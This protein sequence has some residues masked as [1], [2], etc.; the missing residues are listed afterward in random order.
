MTPD[1]TD[2]SDTADDVSVDGER[3]SDVVDKAATRATDGRDTFRPL[4]VDD[5]FRRT[6]RDDHATNAALHSAIEAAAEDDDRI[7]S[8]NLMGSH[9][10]GE[11]DHAPTY[12][13]SVTFANG[14]MGDASTGPTFV[15]R[16]LE[17]GKVRCLKA[18]G[19]ATYADVDVEAGLSAEAASRGT[20]AQATDELTVH[21]RPVE[22]RVE[23]IEVPVGDVPDDF[24][25][26]SKVEQDAANALR[27]AVNKFGVDDPKTQAAE[28]ALGLALSPTDPERQDKPHGSVDD[29]RERILRAADIDPKTRRGTDDLGSPDRPP[30]GPIEE[31]VEDNQHAF[32]ADKGEA[33]EVAEEIADT[34]AERNDVPVRSKCVTFE[35]TNDTATVRR[36]QF[37]GGFTLDLPFCADCIDHFEDSVEGA[38]ADDAAT[39]QSLEADAA[40][41]LSKA[42]ADPSVPDSAI[43]PVARALATIVY[44]SDTEGY[45]GDPS[46]AHDSLWERAD[47]DR[48]D[49]SPDYHVTDVGG[50][51][52]A[53]DAIEDETHAMHVAEAIAVEHGPGEF[54]IVFDGPTDDRVDDAADALAL[55]TADFEPATTEAIQFWRGEYDP[56]FDPLIDDLGVADV[57]HGDF[58]S[59]S[60]RQA[61]KCD[62]HVAVQDKDSGELVAQ[63]DGKATEW[64]EVDTGRGLWNVRVDVGASKAAA[65][66]VTAY[67]CHSCERKALPEDFVTHGNVDGPAC[68]RCGTAVDWDESPGAGE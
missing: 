25:R 11:K 63:L 68:P 59:Y 18:F 9:A 23:P 28:Y 29:T 24:V 61:G 35:C 62:V 36:H 37:P 45:D 1:P 4:S 5:R 38:S 3:I 15:G 19:G 12:Y 66:P 41:V 54:S 60:R 39:S 34:I 51:A 53:H 8:V 49:H 44:T 32:L 46:N 26:Y 31:W 14:G 48:D 56:T 55:A 42:A 22:T 57:T 13:V 2:Q 6:V 40:T 27:G 16:L 47:V 50:E 33:R 20:I 21:L 7:L 67:V 64:N 43:R 30:V 10:P 65:K 58:D 52:W 17:R